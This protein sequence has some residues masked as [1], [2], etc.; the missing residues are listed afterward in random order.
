M[1]HNHNN[2]NNKIIIVTIIIIIVII[3]IIIITITTMINKS[4]WKKCVINQRMQNRRKNWEP[5]SECR[6]LRLAENRDSR[7][8]KQV[9]VSNVKLCKRMVAPPPN[10]ETHAHAHAQIKCSC[11][12]KL[13]GAPAQIQHT[14]TRASV[15][16]V[17]LC[18]GRCQRGHRWSLHIA[19]WNQRPHHTHLLRWRS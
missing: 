12:C 11:A 13:E 1:N 10:P 3:I 17:I 15:V 6:T 5:H 19:L 8:L 4:R 16:L 2:S 7:L 18:C 14:N 9:C